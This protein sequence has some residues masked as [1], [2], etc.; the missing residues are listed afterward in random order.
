MSKIFRGFDAP[1]TPKFNFPRS[2]SFGG[3]AGDPF[4]NIPMVRP[5]TMEFDPFKVNTGQFDPLPRRYT[6]LKGDG[7]APSRRP[8]GD[9]VDEYMEE[10]FGYGGGSKDKGSASELSEQMFPDSEMRDRLSE[11][12]GVGSNETLFNPQRRADSF[13]L[14]E[15]SPTFDAS[16]PRYAE[17][18]DR[19]RQAR[20]A[21]PVSPTGQKRGEEVTA[22]VVSELKKANKDPSPPVQVE[23]GTQPRRGRVERLRSMYE[24][25]RKRGRDIEAGVERGKQKVK[26]M[27]DK[28]ASKS[29]EAIDAAGDKVKEATGGLLDESVDAVKAD[30][31]KSVDDLNATVKAKADSVPKALWKKKTVYLAATPIAGLATW[32]TGTINSVED[33]KL[34]DKLREFAD[35]LNNFFKEDGTFNTF[36]NKVQ[37]LITNMEEIINT[38]STELGNVKSLL[39]SIIDQLKEIVQNTEVGE[40]ED[41]GR[42]S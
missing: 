8:T 11:L 34:S 7:G 4:A 42:G 19:F 29:K 35:T 10:V 6:P 25:L 14:V 36:I 12:K 26:D 39:Q 13:E 3:F 1:K 17:E 28:A 41:E 24:N 33:N 23:T 16:N 32:I 2:Q 40:V 20:Q 27:S 38:V 30:L 18:L 31:K 5:S 15:E 21:Q 9:V 22:E 37:T